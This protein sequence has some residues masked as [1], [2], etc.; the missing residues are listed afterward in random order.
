[1][2]TH[3]YTLQKYAGPA[4]KHT[5]PNCGRSRCFTYY[6]DEAGKLLHETV[7]RC[8][9]ESSCGYH[10]KPR[11]YFAA[12]PE[13][14]VPSQTPAFRDSGTTPPSRTL[15][16]IP[17]DIVN[18]SCNIAVPSHLTAFLS[19]ILDSLALKRVLEDYKV[20][21]TKAHDTIFFQIDTYGRCRTGKI[22]KYDIA[23][24]HRIKD[25]NTP[26]RITWVH[27]V[28]KAARQLPADW[29]LTQCLFG[30][31]LLLRHPDR[32]VALVESEKTAIICATLMPKILW[33]ATGGKSQL[34]EQRLSIL[35]GRHVTAFPD[36]D[37]YAEWSDKL[38]KLSTPNLHI[39]VSNVLEREATPDDRAAHIDIA[40]WLLRWKTTPFNNI[41]DLPK[42]T[43]SD[44]LDRILNL[45][46]A[47]HHT[48]V[49]SLVE[50]FQLELFSV[51]HSPISTLR[52]DD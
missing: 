22:M 38:S 42:E 40:D 25:E 11:D 4:S 46:P 18:R 17:D 13:R 19:T 28:M 20:G 31:H 27:S 32:P 21:V 36:I 1:M 30:E 26:G 35:A 8:D 9:H 49:K 51:S 47:E 10:L 7:G 45:V 48:E 34:S 43:P 39:T 24:G 16:L 50:D 33:L 14:P 44:S 37:A 3:T 52:N 12:H 29:Q 6:V 5:C 2:S 23:T 41:L 15:C